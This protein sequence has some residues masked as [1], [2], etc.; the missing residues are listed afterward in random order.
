MLS[1]CLWPMFEWVCVC[2]VLVVIFALLFLFFAVHLIR[3]L[4]AYAVHLLLLLH[5]YALVEFFRRFIF[6]HCTVSGPLFSA[7]IRNRMKT[8]TL[9]HW[10]HLFRTSKA[11]PI[12]RRSAGLMHILYRNS[13]V[14]R[15]FRMWKTFFYF[16]SFMRNPIG[17]IRCTCMQF[18]ISFR[19]LFFPCFDLSEW[20]VD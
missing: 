19:F 14:E 15:F 11:K 1:P 10:R 6:A 9:T 2:P 7:I 17:H 13:I 18:A 3:M 8:S 12:Q 16:F 4:I 5:S 20:R